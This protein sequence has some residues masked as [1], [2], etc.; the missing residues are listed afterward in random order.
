METLRVFRLKW[1]MHNESIDIFIND[2]F[3]SLR[4][5]VLTSYICR[6]KKKKK[7]RHFISDS[8]KLSDGLRCVFTINIIQLTVH[9]YCR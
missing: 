7:I 3:L 4:R 5:L 8:S 6:Q 9:S 1:R 2:F